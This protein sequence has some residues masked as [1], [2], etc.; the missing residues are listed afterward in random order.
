MKIRNI[1]LSALTILRCLCVFA[2]IATCAR[3]WLVTGESALAPVAQKDF[4]FGYW[5]NGWRKAPTDSSPDLLCIE[6]GYYGFMLDVADLTKARFG[7]LN[8]N[9]DYT[10]ALAYGSR[11]L[12]WISP[13]ELK[14]ELKVN[15]TTYRA[16]SCRAGT[17]R[18]VKRLQD[19]RLWES[20]RFV[21][22]FD[23][24]D[25]KFKD[26]AGNELSCYGV[27][28]LVAW[29]G[30]LTLTSELTPSLVYANGPNLGV[31][32]NSLCVIDAPLDIPHSPAIDPETITVE[33][34]VNMPATLESDTHG[35]LICKNENEWKEGNYGFIYNNGKVTSVLNIGGGKQNQHQIKQAHGS[36]TPDVWHHLAL[37]YDGKTMSF[38][39]DGRLQGAE[40][41][42]RIRTP[43]TGLLR[44]GKRADGSLSVVSAL[45]DQ[46]HVWDRAL[47]AEEIAGHAAN[48]A[49]LPSKMGL[50]FEKNFDE[51]P[52]IASPAWTDAE[53]SV[54]LKSD[55]LE[56][57]AET[58]VAG[59]WKA[60]ER[61]QVTLTCDLR[62]DRR[63]EKDISIHVSAPNNQTFPV[64]FENRFNCNVT[65]VA[66][67]KRTWE[68][69]SAEIR[70]YDEF[71]IVLEN[72]G[73]ESRIVPFLLDFVRPA[74]I[75]GLCPI[76]CD[77]N[78][79]PTGI[80]V[81]LSKNWHYFPIGPYLRAYALLP[82]QSGKTTYKMRI[83]YGFYGTLPTASHSQLSLV[84]YG[85]NGRWDQMAIGCWGETLCLDM[86]MSCTDV[87]I[88]DVRCLMLRNGL[89]GKKWGWTDAGWGG[90]WLSAEGR[91][92]D[93]L[94]FNELKTA[95]LAH[96]PCLTDVRY[97]GHYGAGREVNLKAQVQTL[98]TDDYARTFQTFSYTFDKNIS[99]KKGCLFKVGGTGSLVTPQIA[100]GNGNG[101]IEERAVPKNLKPNELFAD[102]VTLSGDGPWW[103]AFPGAVPMDGQDWGT[104]SRSLIIRSYQATIDGRKYTNPT[105]SMPVHNVQKD[106]RLDLDLLL[107]PPAGVAEFK[108]G[109][110]VKLDVELITLPRV[111][112]DYYGP[113]ESFRKHIAENPR[114]WKTTYREAKGND[115]KI[116]VAGGTKLNN[117]PIVIQADK[118][119][120]KVEIEGGIGFVPIRFEGL[121]SAN[122]YA[123]YQSVGG[124]QIKLD[125]SV[126]G[127]DYWQ[128]DFD[129]KSNSFKMTFNL[130]LDGLGKSEWILKK[131]NR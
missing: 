54:R 30:S 37:S 81:Q 69:A 94:L 117:Y 91:N 123:L 7:L 127:N 76:L 12:Q 125:Q 26:D 18:D 42:G 86:D 58:R 64:T 27:L 110:A 115:L 78:G 120:V 106:G 102:K 129:V 16:V 53:M 43:G 60:G 32:G 17:S 113:N 104:G 55:S 2:L 49:Q 5:L 8:D 65:R 40:T 121:K 90:D 101:L 96:G 118:P 14:I 126:H 52:V 20:G 50:T 11:R 75:T 131:L 36:L 61:Q 100:Y 116:Q 22:H 99:V 25:L 98:R 122:D 66:N 82:A 6:S 108:P 1:N 103:V 71:N 112:D 68:T 72:A 77:E 46:V 31:S 85:R 51:G 56:W 109:D 114:S 79:V 24:L 9:F 92:G 4:S 34:W 62:N 47:S 93:K 3:C 33:C 63:S 130:P 57:H 13:A 111:A 97:D 28:D 39:L 29:P 95:Y 48:P 45:Y 15:N 74:N 70:N 84:G 23:L 89:N 80:P 21:Q 107:M 19:V 105:I 41:I 35:W 119:E 83:P 44:I 59:V 73:E 88:T 128:T 38:Y 124:K 10:Q 67:L 87:A